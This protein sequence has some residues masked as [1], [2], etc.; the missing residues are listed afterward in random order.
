MQWEPWIASVLPKKGTIRN[1]LDIGCNKGIWSR[2]LKEVALGT[3]YCWDPLRDSELAKEDRIE[4]VTMAAWDTPNKLQFNFREDETTWG[5]VDARDCHRGKL[6]TPKEVSAMPV[7]SYSYQE[8]DFVKIDVEG[9]EVQTL[10]G[11]TKLIEEQH[12]QVLV[13]MHEIENRRWCETWL[14]RAG[15]NFTVY[16]GTG[17][18]PNTQA[19][20]THCWVHFHWAF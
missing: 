2:A 13:E 11:M 14:E 4:F 20:L 9:S 12:P 5:A 10:M 17:Y 8:I 3:V 16:H 15:Y 6:H 1:A 19:W 18:E 7:D